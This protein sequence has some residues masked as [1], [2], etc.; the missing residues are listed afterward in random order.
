[1]HKTQE[2][3][4][5]QQLQAHQKG[6]VS[7]TQKSNPIIHRRCQLRVCAIYFHH[8]RGDRDAQIYVHAALG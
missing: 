5:I 1:M 7:L 8:K 3:N 4:E 6:I 2:K